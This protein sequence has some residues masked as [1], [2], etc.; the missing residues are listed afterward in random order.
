MYKGTTIL[1]APKQ[2]HG[3]TGS[4]SLVRRFVQRLTETKPRITTVLEFAP[5]EAAPVEFGQGSLIEDVFSDKSL[6]TWL[7]IMTLAG[8]RHQHAELVRD[9][10]VDTCW[11][12]TDVR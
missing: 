12:V 11:V 9:Q 1:A 3:F 4:Y 2:R 8:S 6:T 10:L 7:F 5:G